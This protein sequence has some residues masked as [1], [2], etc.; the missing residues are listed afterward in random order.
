M[1]VLHGGQHLLE[2]L[3]GHLLG[4]AQAR[5][6][7]LRD[8]GHD[9]TARRALQHDD[10]AVLVLHVADEV[11]NVRVPTHARHHVHLGTHVLQVLVALELLAVDD[12]DGDIGAVGQLAGVHLQRR[13]C[14]AQ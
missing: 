4:E 2:H 5:V 12:L 8:A 7:Q 11:N 6:H 13:E 3:A 1:A 10:E 9:L 14:V